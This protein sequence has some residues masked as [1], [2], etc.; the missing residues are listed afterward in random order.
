MLIKPKKVFKLKQKM[1][2][3]FEVKTTINLKKREKTLYKVLNSN[4]N[5]SENTPKS[6]NLKISLYLNGVNTTKKQRYLSI[7]LIPFINNY[8][9]I[10][11]FL[12]I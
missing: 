10:E 1:W 3:N 9:Y 12:S 11:V 6:F 2:K 7:T 5:V 4:K 8:V